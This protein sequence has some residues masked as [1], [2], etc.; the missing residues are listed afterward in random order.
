MKHDGNQDDLSQDEVRERALRILARIIAYRHLAM[1]TR[2]GI[3]E[4]D[5]DSNDVA[6]SRVKQRY[7]RQGK[8]LDPTF[9][10]DGDEG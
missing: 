3:A 9:P 7:R 5:I 8:Q 6:E 1:S 4:G 2:T 10:I